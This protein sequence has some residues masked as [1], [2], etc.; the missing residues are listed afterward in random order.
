MIG[1]TP[2]YAGPELA[3]FGRQRSWVT[4]RV[5]PGLTAEAKNLMKLKSIVHN[6]PHVAWSI[7]AV[8][9]VALCTGCGGSGGSS[10]VPAGAAPASIGGLGAQPAAQSAVLSKNATA[11]N[12]WPTYG[13]NNFHNGYN[14]NSGLF[15]VAELTTVPSPLHLA[16]HFTSN[17]TGSQTQPILATNIGSHAGVLFVG[18]RSGVVYAVDA[19]TGKSIWSRSLGTEQ[20]QCVNGGPL[21]KLG[22][23][24][25]P[26]YD[27]V[28]N[29]VYVTDGTNATPNAPVTITIY[30][31][32]PST[33]ATLGSVN[34]TPNNLPGEID[35]AHTALTLVSGTLYEGTGSTCDL[36]SWRGRLAAVNAG[37]MTLG[38][39]FFPTYGQGAAYSG[40]GVWGWGGAAVDD[41]GHVYIGAG[42]ADINAGRIGPKAPFVAT[43]DEQA[44]Y[45]E[46]AIKLSSDLSSVLSSHAVPYGFSKTVT[47]LDLS[48]SP[49]L[50]TPTGCQPILAI[51]GKAGLL[52]FYHT[53][54]LGTGPIGSFQF[55]ESGDNVSYIGNGTY[56]PMTGLYYANVPTSS[57]GSIRPPGLV[58]ISV[59]SCNTP[60]IVLDSQ[61]GADSYQIGNFDGTPRSAPSVTAGN[62]V[63]VASPLASGRSQLWA[64]DATN[65]TVLNGGSPLLTTAAFVRMP[66]VVDGQWVYVQDQSGNLYGLTINQSA[67]T[68]K[69]DFAE[70]SEPSMKW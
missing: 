27:P 57:G 60:T 37:A 51:Q 20:M 63:F 4:L 19:L 59:T 69:A 61:F 29:V 30:K 17:E 40:G 13:Y 24:G 33:G 34:M 65:G 25:T 47:N 3:Q 67:P 26:V 8:G 32:S 56:S 6:R 21:L 52:N 14:P 28:A 45:G 7:V 12:V 22:V 68:I 64:I 5:R 55:S 42:N 10:S 70:S 36:S 2:G 11:F 54:N 58:G 43:T 9:L 18:G 50:F 48:G 66:P 44:G 23:Q 38:N 46:H 31:L 62:V 49:V 39:T 15:T 1:T 53:G 41:Q 35:F 16:W